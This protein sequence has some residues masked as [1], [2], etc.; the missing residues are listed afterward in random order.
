V[1]TG[2]KIVWID[3]TNNIRL[4][5]SVVWVTA[6]EIGTIWENGADIVYDVDELVDIMD[7]SKK[8]GYMDYDLSEIRD[9]KLS[10]ILKSC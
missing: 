3:I 5:G 8:L 2:D 4:R 1:K 7:K 10:Q 6:S 9:K